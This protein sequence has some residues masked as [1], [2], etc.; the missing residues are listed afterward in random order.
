MSKLCVHYS[1]W[2]IIWVLLYK[3][4][5]INYNPNFSLSLALIHNIIYLSTSVIKKEINFE[6]KYITL[7]ISIKL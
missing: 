6:K 1:D 7:I 3:F 4:N 2:I 5:I